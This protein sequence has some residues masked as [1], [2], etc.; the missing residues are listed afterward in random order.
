MKVTPLLSDQLPFLFPIGH[1]FTEEVGRAAF[2]ECS[3]ANAWGS[4][5]DS[6]YGEIYVVWSS[7]P[8]TRDQKII[9][10]LGASFLNDPFSGVLTA[11]EM[12]W[13]VLPEFRK[14]G[15]GLMLLDHFEEQAE[16]RGCSEILMVHFAH[17]GA[18]LQKLYESRGFSLLE[19]TFRKES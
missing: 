12:F 6:G 11:S 10:A 7:G 14:T 3:F 9:A 18:G 16:A 5:L 2:S 15:A 8:V 19:Q 1:A 4:L 17:M 13:Y